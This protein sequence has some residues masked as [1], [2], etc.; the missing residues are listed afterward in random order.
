VSELH[1]LIFTALISFLLGF[2]VAA[3]LSSERRWKAKRS[4]DGLGS[5]MKV[6]VVL[7]TVIEG[8]VVAIFSTEEKARA[9]VTANSDWR[10]A[11]DEDDPEY[12]PFDRI[13]EF[14]VDAGAVKAP[15]TSP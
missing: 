10:V 9:Y 7:N 3:H 15:E 11:D 2:K 5:Q 4:R 1:D 12:E 14:E 6:Y 8:Y 13:E